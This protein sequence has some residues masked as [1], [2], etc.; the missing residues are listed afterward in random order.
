VLLN[1]T[2]WLITISETESERQYP[3]LMI[4]VNTFNPGKQKKLYSMEITISGC[5]DCPFMQDIEHDVLDDDGDFVGLRYSYYCKHPQRYMQD[6]I[7][8]GQGVITPSDC[9]LY[10]EP[11]IVKI[12]Q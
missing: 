2:Q 1:F 9:P 11:A 6:M 4:T 3:L 8:L 12:N 7:D 5:Q 10:K